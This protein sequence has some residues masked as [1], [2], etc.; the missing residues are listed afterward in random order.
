M[1]LAYFCLGALDL[2][3]VIDTKLAPEERIE[4]IDWIYDQQLE[5][6]QGGGFCASPFLPKS[7]AK[8]NLAMTYTAILNLAI[9]RDDFKRLKKAAILTHIRFLQQEDGR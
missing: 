2:L 6:D 4:Y 7:I 8:S 1:T 3:K 9:L 5:L